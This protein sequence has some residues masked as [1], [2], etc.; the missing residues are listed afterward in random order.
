MIQ[1][2]DAHFTPCTLGCDLKGAVSQAE[3][4]GMTVPCSFPSEDDNISFRSFQWCKK[5]QNGFITGTLD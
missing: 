3:N 5:R 1:T 4:S 2:A